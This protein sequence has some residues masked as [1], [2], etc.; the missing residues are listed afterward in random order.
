MN[1]IVKKTIAIIAILTMI[2]SMTACGSNQPNNN[3]FETETEQTEAVSSGTTENGNNDDTENET[4]ASKILVVN[5]SCTGNTRPIADKVTEMLDA[6]FYEIVPEIPYTEDDINYSV[7]DCRANRE[8]NDE[9]ARPEIAGEKLDIS[10]YDTVIISFPI[11][12]GKEPRIIDTFMETYDFTGKTITCFCTSGGSGIGTAESNLHACAKEATWLEG[13][14]F[15]SGASD[16]DI[17]AWLSNIGVAKRREAAGK[18]QEVKIRFTDGTNEVIV[19]LNDSKL[20]ESLVAQLPFTF[21]FE[22]YAHNEKNGTV[23]EKLTTDKNFE[24]EC[25]KGSLGY[26]A[27]WGNLCLFFEVAP[28]YPGQYVL[29]TVEGDSDDIKKLGNKVTVEIAE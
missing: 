15:E 19:L 11:W 25:P 14:R 13:I 27:P 22:D 2:L 6:D 26:F 9:N 10:A 7:D 24:A 29:G 20:S 16:S 18:E 3:V 5:F 23:P 28:A 8:Q 17:E 4:I 1:D 21:D 12:W